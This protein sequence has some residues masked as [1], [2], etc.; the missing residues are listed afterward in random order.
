LG[1]GVTNGCGGNNQS[2]IN[3]LRE[4]DPGFDYKIYESKDDAITKDYKNQIDATVAVEPDTTK[5]TLVTD[6]NTANTFTSQ[7]ASTVFGTGVTWDGLQF[8][9]HAGSEHTVNGK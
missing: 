9:M 2:P 1:A 3:L 7:L 4:G 8:H 6:V 5:V